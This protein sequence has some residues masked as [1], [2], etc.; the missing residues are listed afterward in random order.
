[1]KAMCG[2]LGAVLIL[3]FP[4]TS[5]AQDF[6]VTTISADG[7]GETYELLAEKLGG[8]PVEAPDC[9]HTEPFK[10]IEEVYDDVLDRYVFKFHIHADTDTDRCKTNIDRQR[11]EIKAYDPSPD[12]LKGIQREEVV[13]EWFFKMDAQFQPSS[14]FTHVFQLKAVGGSDADNPILTIT[15]R[16]GEPN[17]LE[18]IHGKGGGKYTTVAVTELSSIAGQWVSIYCKA[19]YAEDTGKLDFKIKLLDGTEVLSYSSNSIDLWR[20]GSNFVRPKWGIYRSLNDLASLRDEEVLFADF[21]VSEKGACPIWYEDA[22][23][24]GLG[25]PNSFIYACIRPDGYVQN[26]V[27]VCRTWYEDA[28]G[29]GLGNAQVSQYW[30][31]Q[32]E[33]YVSNASDTNDLP[34][35]I[36]TVVGVF[37]NP[38]SGMLELDGYPQDIKYTITDLGGKVLKNGSGTHI[39][40]SSFKTGLYLL[41]TNDGGLFKIVKQ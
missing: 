34:L 22:D 25:D 14:N 18:L 35:A 5:N 11:N 20:L 38:T 30:C 9:D 12:N 39:D 37:P 27:D 17:K 3:L 16:K 36:N 7:P 32:P 1:M 40:L 23:T 29:D 19:I 24:D 10:H 6:T 31:N 28:D 13:Y 4:K 2:L 41:K 33:G 26:K 8:S 21:K 15:P